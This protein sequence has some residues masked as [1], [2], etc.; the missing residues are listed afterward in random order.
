MSG[1]SMTDEVAEEEVEPGELSGNAAPSRL[2]DVSPVL[3]PT[4]EEPSPGKS[5]SRHMRYRLRPN[6]A[7]SQRLKDFVC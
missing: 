7:P 2:P 4:E 1:E 3:P 5:D 6:Q